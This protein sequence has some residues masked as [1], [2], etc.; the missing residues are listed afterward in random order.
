MGGM[1]GWR[2][3]IIP[4]RYGITL[5]MGIQMVQSDLKAIKPQQHMGMTTLE[6]QT[7]AYWYTSQTIKRGKFNWD[8]VMVL[9]MIKGITRSNRLKEM[10]TLGRIMGRK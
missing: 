10:A 6:Q 3:G 5:T 7:L 9:S 4:M 2:F 8:E 1:G